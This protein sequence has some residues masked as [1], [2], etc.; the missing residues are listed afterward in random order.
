MSRWGA[1]RVGR[2]KEGAH[3]LAGGGERVCGPQV[4][5]GA[6]RTLRGPASC[7]CVPHAALDEM[8]ALRA[9]LGGDCGDG[10]GHDG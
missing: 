7:G 10:E 6:C 2:G 3:V 4:E 5:G 9:E 8:W 1:V